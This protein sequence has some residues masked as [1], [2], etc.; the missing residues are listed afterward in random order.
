MSDTD[1]SSIIDSEDSLDE[2]TDILNDRTDNFGDYESDASFGSSITEIGDNNISGAESNTSTVVETLY[3]TDML[4][5]TSD[6]SVSTDSIYDMYLRD[7]ISDIITEYNPS[8]PLRLIHSD[9]SD[10]S[11]DADNVSI[12]YVY[13]DSEGSE[14]TDMDF[15]DLNTTHSSETESAMRA[16]TI[17]N[18][19]L[20]YEYIA[21]RNNNNNNNRTS[22]VQCDA[23]HNALDTC[24]ICISTFADKEMV[25]RLPCFHLYH[26]DCID[27]WFRSGHGKCPICRHKINASTNRLIQT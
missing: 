6:S 7:N 12:H 13:G 1:M 27:E 26:K 20:T 16:N 22:S 17:E 14:D 9:S 11:D 10:S 23:N 8:T 24:T 25:R 21:D 4:S 3:D 2:L 15:I 5:M 18:N 19:T